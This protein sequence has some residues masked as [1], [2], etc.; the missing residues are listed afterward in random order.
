IEQ[1]SPWERGRVLAPEL[2]NLAAASARAAGRGDGGTAGVTA[3]GAWDVLEVRGPYAEG[4]RLLEGARSVPGAPDVAIATTLS[5][6]FAAA[7]RSAEAREA[8]EWALARASDPTE[9]AVALLERAVLDREAGRAD[10]ARVG[11]EEALASFRARGESWLEARTALQLGWCE[12][13]RG[14]HEAARTWYASALALARR[15]G[16]LRVEGLARSRLASLCLVQGPLADVEAHC[17]AALT[18]ER[19]GGYAADEART[20]TVLGIA[21]S[22][23]G[24]LDEAEDAFRTALAQYRALG[25][26]HGEA[27]ALGHL[28]TVHGHRGQLD[29]SCALF[30]EAVAL[31]RA[32]GSPSYVAL[33]LGN[34][35][36]TTLFRGA[37]ADARAALEEALAIDRQLDQAVPIGFVQ[38]RLG[39]LH[40]LAGEPEQARAAWIEARDVLRDARAPAQLALCLIRLAEADRDDALADEAATLGAPFPEVAAEVLAERAVQR[41]RAGRFAEA[42]ADARRA[43]GCGQIGMTGAAVAAARAL[44]SALTGDPGAAA[45]IAAAEQLL[46]SM[47][48]LPSAEVARRVAEAGRLVASRR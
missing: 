25:N 26:R 8:V 42:R 5:R 14:A 13:G 46:A 3:L 35:G 41:A 6:A 10:L 45:A 2:D 12:H 18:V 29:A 48:V 7:G 11:F 47:E 44:V 33:F 43:V 4:I 1:T 24:R 38:T 15:V 30:A 28:G 34:L 19:A 31:H 27:T 23:Q 36:T 17:E 21:R 16:D 39:D 32:L 9:R 22:M 40:A 37:T 20:R